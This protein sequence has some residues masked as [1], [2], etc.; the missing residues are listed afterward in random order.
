MLSLIVCSAAARKNTVLAARPEGRVN[1][2]GAAHMLRLIRVRDELTLR[3]AVLEYAHS[4][5][6][7]AKQPH[8]S[9]RR[10]S[11]LD[12][13]SLINY[14]RRHP[15]ETGFRRPTP[16]AETGRSNCRLGFVHQGDRR[17]RYGEKRSNRE[18]RYPI[19]A[20]GE[21]AINLSEHRARLIAQSTSLL[22]RND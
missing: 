10:Y 7:S 5:A 4:P 9:H 11:A 20:L 8:N 21:P 1:R 22:F 13:P 16:S 2:E 12:Y 6:T 19:E 18:V 15:A 14:E 17:E 3:Q